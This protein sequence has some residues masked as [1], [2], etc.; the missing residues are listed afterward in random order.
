MNDYT[1][2]DLINELEKASKE[3]HLFYKQDFINYLGK[4]TDTNEYYTE[5]ICEWLL[6]HKE[7]LAQDI[8]ITRQSTYFVDSHDGIPPTKDSNRTEELIAMAMFRQKNFNIIGEIIDYQTPLKNKRDDKAGKIDLLSYDG[9]HIRILE[10]KTPDSTETMLR[11]VLEGYTYLKTVDQDKLKEDYIKS[12]SSDK[13]NSDSAFAQSV[14]A[15]TVSAHPLVFLGEAQ[16]KEMRDGRPNLKKL[17]DFLGCNP[18]YI[19][20]NNNNNIVEG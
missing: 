19:D 2:K 5:V 1:K 16:Y 18:Y 15:S 11:C 13:N 20:K 8:C 17:I 4:T 14:R 7:L 6:N 10:L 9:K 12:K 3:M